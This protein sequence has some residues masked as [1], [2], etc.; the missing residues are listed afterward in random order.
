[1]KTD[2]LLNYKGYSAEP[3]YSAADGVFYGT[4]QGVDDLVDFQA[5]N[6]EDLEKEF[7]KA[8]DEYL[9]FCAEIGRE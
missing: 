7:H 3:E 4:V 9:K 1:M 2:T 8:V 6:A 5:E